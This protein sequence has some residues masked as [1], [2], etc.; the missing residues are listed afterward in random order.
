MHNKLVTLTNVNQHGVVLRRSKIY[1]GTLN[2]W[3]PGSSSNKDIKKLDF[4]AN[5]E[6]KKIYLMKKEME[7]NLTGSKKRQHLK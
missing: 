7:H 1:I 2:M 6:V 3:S 4:M 5:L